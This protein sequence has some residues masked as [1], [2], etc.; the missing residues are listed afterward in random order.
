MFSFQMLELHKSTDGKLLLSPHPHWPA[1]LTC[2]TAF[3]DILQC[4]EATHAFKDNTDDARF[5]ALLKDWREYSKKLS[6][7]AFKA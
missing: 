3:F 4:F 6:E 1:V 2:H 5:D 7:T